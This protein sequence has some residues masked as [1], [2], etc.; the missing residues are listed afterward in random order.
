[1]CEWWSFEV[2]QVFAA[3]GSKVA[4]EQEHDVAVFSIGMNYLLLLFAMPAGIAVSA[5]TFIGNSLG[6]N[7]PAAA[8][9]YF[10]L[11]ISIAICAS[12]FTSCLT[13]VLGKKLFALYTTDPV[14]LEGLDRTIPLLMVC[15][16]CDCCQTS[17]QGVFRG[18][19]KQNRSALLVLM[20][21][22]GV[23]LPMAFLL[24]V[25]AGMR[26][27]GV[28][29]GFLCGMAVE[30]PLLLWDPL[31]RWDWKELAATA[32]AKMAE[33]V[34]TSEVETSE[35]DRADEAG[36]ELGMVS[37]H[38]KKSPPSDAEGLGSRE[39]SRGGDFTPSGITATNHRER[40]E[41]AS[42]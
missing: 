34:E 41:Y 11:A 1:M 16:V 6:A 4:L 24:G 26:V 19:G 20:S 17:L 36:E 2:L 14:L 13:F 28:W 33:K 40:F 5:S 31:F 29:L 23:G 7:R 32:S 21:L 42:P 9:K 27:T 18:A 8:K 35:K 39:E 10:R 30:V 12:A 37:G 3:R 38:A 25:V 22:W 15:H